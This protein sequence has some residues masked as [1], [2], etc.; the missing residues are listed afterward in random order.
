MLPGNGASVVRPR[1]KSDSLF[2]RSKLG[3][4]AD[5]AARAVILR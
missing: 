1:Y 5:G 3:T 2:A 4:I